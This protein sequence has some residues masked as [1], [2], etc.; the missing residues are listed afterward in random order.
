MQKH[1]IIRYNQK[2]GSEYRLTGIFARKFK[3][4]QVLSDNL[5]ILP[6]FGEPKKSAS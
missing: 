6:L 2:E 5:Q 4:L 1:D 3:Q